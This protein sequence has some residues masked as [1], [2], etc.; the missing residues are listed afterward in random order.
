MPRAAIAVLALAAVAA[1]SL[2]AR[3]PAA[4]ERYLPASPAELRR[5]AAG[6]VFSKA[7]VLERREV[8]G[9]AAVRVSTTPERV[10]AGFRKLSGFTRSELVR[11]IGRVAAVPAPADFAHLTLDPSEVHALEECRPSH[12]DFKLTASQIE[13]LG[14]DVPWRSPGAHAAAEALFRSL[15]A[16]EAA[17]YLRGGVGSL[18]PLAAQRIPVDRARELSLLMANLGGLAE[19]APEL[20]RDVEQPAAGGDTGI[21]QFLYWSKIDLGLKPVISLNHIRIYR[22]PPPSNDV[23]VVSQQVY[24]NHYFDASVGITAL[25]TPDPGGPMY[26]LYVNRSRVDFLTGFF[27]PI[28]RQIVRGRVRGGLEKNLRLART[29]LESGS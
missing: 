28:T 11:Q 17:R 14:R 3:Q 12:C 27:G 19:I 15:L 1:G 4:L 22:K 18:E 20:R 10:I 25:V 8:V 23:V 5:L 24:A 6:A 7:D 26:L 29:H 2:H 9:A 13:R 16:E 21:E